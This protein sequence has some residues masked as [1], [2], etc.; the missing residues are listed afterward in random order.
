M[1]INT[2]EI[3]IADY[4]S[5]WYLVNICSINYELAFKWQKQIERVPL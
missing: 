4:F 3:N 5:H 1:C 2:Q